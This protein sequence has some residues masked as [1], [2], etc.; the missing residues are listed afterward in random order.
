MA[1]ILE[2]LSNTTMVLP[3]KGRK[4]FFLSARL[5][6]RS[7]LLARP[8][9]HAKDGCSKPQCM[10]D[11]DTTRNIALFSLLFKHDLQLPF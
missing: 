1:L 6:G 9:G 3:L 10:S 5:F 8:I 7:L 4:N 2:L 11:Q